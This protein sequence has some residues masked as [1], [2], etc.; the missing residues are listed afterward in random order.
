[1]RQVVQGPPLQLVESV[2]HHVA[3]SVLRSFPLV[4][5]VSVRVLKPHVAMPGAL[6]A[7]G[8]WHACVGRV[9]LAQG[10]LACSG[11]E[12]HRVRGDKSLE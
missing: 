5:A 10:D 12:I 1:M 4:D 11:V 8:A 6:D 2:A 7:L 9:R 3:A